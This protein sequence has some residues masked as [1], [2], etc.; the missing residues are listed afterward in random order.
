MR[1]FLIVAS[2]ALG[3]SACATHESVG[4]Q[5]AASC[6]AVGITEKDPQFATCSEAYSRQ[7]L[8]GRLNES[9]HNALNPTPDDRRIRH[10]WVY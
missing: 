5:A 9:F 10:N 7:Y 1:N 3:L 8:E 6:Q 4:R 2:I